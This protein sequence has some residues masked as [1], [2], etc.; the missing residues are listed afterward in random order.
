MKYFTPGLELNN[1]V[2]YT[3]QLDLVSKMIISG[4]ASAIVCKNILPTNNNIVARHLQGNKPFDVTAVW[5]K[6]RFLSSAAA[7]LLDT[8]RL[9]I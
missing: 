2:T 3:N 1:I 9:P 5:K 7:K 6:D 4:K 8:L